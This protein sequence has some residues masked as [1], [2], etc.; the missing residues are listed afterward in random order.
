MS[1]QQKILLVEDDA[2]LAKFHKKKLED[3]GLDITYLANGSQVVETAKKEQPKVIV[4]DLIMPEV[5]GFTA[6]KALKQDPTTKDIPVVILSS[7][8]EAED[9]AELKKMG[10]KKHF[11]KSEVNI[12]TVIDF[13]IAL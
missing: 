1:Q 11:N 10:I 3:R 5:D 4:L 2:F 9:I 8:N 13:L 6:L 7:L 12:N